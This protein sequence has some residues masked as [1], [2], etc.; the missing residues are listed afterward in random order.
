MSRNGSDDFQTP[1]EAVVPLVPYLPDHWTIWECACGKGYLA[2]AL[3]LAGRKVIATDQK[4][5]NDFL[6]WQPADWQCALTNPP[7]SLKNEFLARAYALGKPFAFLLPLTALESESRQR[8]FHR[9]GIQVMLLDKRIHFETPNK[10][11]SHPWF[12]VAWFCWKLNLPKQ[13]TFVDQDNEPVFAGDGPT[14]RRL[15]VSDII[16]DQQYRH[17]LGDIPALAESIGRF[18]L[19]RPILIT[20]DGRLIA[21]LRRL[22][23]CKLLRWETIPVQIVGGNGHEQ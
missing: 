18:G 21:G 17:D 1:P 3:R 11:P 6:T 22:E 12:P 20:V 15:P 10:K 2:E 5:G 4:D 23:A 9:H 19:L 7:F 14:I 13:L 8:L 16:I